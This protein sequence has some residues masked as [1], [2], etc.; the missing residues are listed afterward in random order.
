LR[1]V[2]ILAVKEM[3]LHRH[4]AHPSWQQIWQARDVLWSFSVP[5]ALASAIG[6][7]V[8]W[9]GTVLLGSANDGFRDVAVVTVAN[10]WR[11]VLLLGASILSSV[12]IPMMTRLGQKGDMPGISQLHSYN[13]KVNLGISFAA[14]AV[15]GAASQSIL[16]AY[17]GEFGQGWPVFVLL[18]ATAIPATYANVLLQYLVSQRRM[19]QQ[20]IYY[21]LS[22]AALLVAYRIA[23]TAW[24]ALGFATATFAVQVIS[25]FMLDW[26]LASALTVG[27]RR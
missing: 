18:V 8:A 13:M 20:L 24:G 7:A 3:R 2:M 14:A 25:A 21:L 23:I 16:R 27:T 10:Q 6:G 26:L 17:G 12:A 19:W 5:S 9:Y 15:L 22:S 4:D 1:F 11:G